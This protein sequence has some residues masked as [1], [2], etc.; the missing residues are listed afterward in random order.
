L[1]HNR[2]MRIKLGLAALMTCSVLASG[3]QIYFGGHDDD[4]SVPDA[5]PPCLMT[6]DQG[7]AVPVQELRNPY[8]GQCVQGGGW[9]CR[10]GTDP[11]TGADI[12]LDARWPVCEN[13][14]NA[15]GEADCLGA[16]G[17]RAI[18]IENGTFAAC[19]AT[20]SDGPVR[21]GDC[22]A[23]AD[24]FECSQHDD[25]SALHGSAAGTIS[26]WIRCLPEN[27]V[28][29]GVCTCDGDCPMGSHCDLSTRKCI[30]D[31][32]PPPPPPPPECA[33]LGEPTCIDM[34]DGCITQPDGQVSC[35]DHKCE[36][37][38]SGVGCTCNST[39][40]CTCQDWIYETCREA[41]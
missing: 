27:Q 16:D 30:P 32:P 38:Y 35:G 22:S 17:C 13:Y 6:D 1:L 9:D 18:Y 23:I 28:D 19:W 39:G 7:I 37:I 3:C 29:P 15:L 34:A 31:Q 26:E 8:T 41:T 11:A 10:Y 4:D 25:C 14:C 40:A 12:W 5:G 24:A 33:G 36:P 20:A 2:I 21:G